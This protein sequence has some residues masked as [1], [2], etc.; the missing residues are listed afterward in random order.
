MALL[1]DFKTRF[2]EFDTNEVD[3]AWPG[4]ESLWP[5]L[6]GGT[7]GASTCVDNVILYLTA[8]LFYLGSMS[9]TGPALATASE[10][11]GSVSVTN[12]VNTSMSSQQSYYGS[13]K[14]GQMFLNLTKHRHGT[15]FV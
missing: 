2:P 12:V 14:Y 13:T 5:C 11:V 3:T 4:V 1:D 10:S 9:D 7:Y 15:C 6:Y 8:H